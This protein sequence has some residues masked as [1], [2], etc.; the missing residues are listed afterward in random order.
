MRRIYGRGDFEHVGYKLIDEP[1]HRILAVQAVEKAWGPTYVRFGLSLSSDFRGDNAFNLLASIRRTWL[2]HLGGEWRADVQ[3]GNDGLLFTEFYQPLVPNQYFFIAPRAQVVRVPADI[4]GGPNGDDLAAR[5]NVSIGTVGLDL[6]SQFTKYG[7][8]RVGVLAGQGDADLQIGSP[9][10]AQYSIKRDIGAVRARLYLDQLDSTSFP[11][12][13]YNLDAQIVAS[14]TRLGASDSY[15]RWNAGFLGATVLRRAHLPVRAG[16]RRRDR[17]QPAAAL[18]LPELRR[19]HAHDRLPR[20]AVAQRLD[21]LWP[22]DLHE[23]AVQDA[24][25]RRCVRRRVDRGARGWASR[26]C[27]PASRATSPRAACSWRWT[28][29]WARPTWPTATP[30]RQQQRLLLPSGAGADAAAATRSRR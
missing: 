25:A 20:R 14:T 24:A 10:L 15:N 7:E 12:S 18:R 1:D 2:N 9:I 26:W 11:R 3:L 17:R 29:R 4:Y 22:P 28:R 5:Y 21:E 27:P 19:L 23:P 16:R 6:G 13:G 30:R 8:L